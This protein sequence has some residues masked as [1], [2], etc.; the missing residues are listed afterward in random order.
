MKTCVSRP[1]SGP[2]T[3]THT[4]HGNCIF[5]FLLCCS[6][7]TACG[8]R[9]SDRSTWDR[10]ALGGTK[11]R[12]MKSQLKTATTQ[13]T[14]C[15]CERI[16]C[17]AMTDRN[18]SGKLNNN[19]TGHR[20]IDALSAVSRSVPSHQPVHAFQWRTG[21]R[22]TESDMWPGLCARNGSILFV[23]HNLCVLKIKTL[24][25]FHQLRCGACA[26]ILWLFGQE[27]V[28]TDRRARICHTKNTM[29]LLF[30]TQ[31]KRLRPASA[32]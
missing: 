32:I 6:D 9:A 31:T 20:R 26:R 17:A 29:Y 16:N 28:Q 11:P 27:V 24:Q 1:H 18:V 7:C 21:D 15:F 3:L 4:T 23:A 22:E 5:T 13:P 2:H 19:A 12:V 14:R 25:T 30:I 10:T 8:K